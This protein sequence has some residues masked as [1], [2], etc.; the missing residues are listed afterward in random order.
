MA[1]RKLPTPQ[2][3]TDRWLLQQIKDPGWAVIGIPQ[4]GEAP[5]YAFSVGIFHTL[6]HPEIVIMGLSPEV[7]QN[8]INTIA[9]AVRQGRHFEAGQQYD[10]ITTGPPLAFLTM[11]ERHYREYLGYARWFYR[12]SDF[13]VLQCVWPDKERRFPWDEGYDGDYFAWQRLLGA[14]GPSFGEWLF[15]DP[16]NVATF[17]MRQVI[18]EGQPILLVT[19]DADD[20][21][22]QFLTGEP[23]KVSDALIVC[24]REM[25]KRDPSLTE[26]ADLPA[27]WRAWRE[28]AE[29]AWQREPDKEDD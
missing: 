6:G 26:L 29:A 18:H 1:K 20:G 23:P 21:A 27:G 3:D 8:L 16:P 24:L 19:H 25:V 10:D 9:V 12:G 7:A 5:P 14:W 11:S 13:P 4:E 28:S 2:D 22:W 15:P 17:T